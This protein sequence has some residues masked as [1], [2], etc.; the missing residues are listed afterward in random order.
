MCE[1]LRDKVYGLLSF[2]ASC[3][4][5]AIPVDYSLSKYQV[6]GL[7]LEHYCRDHIHGERQLFPKSAQ[8][9]RS[10]LDPASI[11]VIRIY[12]LSNTVLGVTSVDRRPPRHSRSANEAELL[13]LGPIIRRLGLKSQDATQSGLRN[14][15]SFHPDNS[16][17]I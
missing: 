16:R 1:D 5:L 15:Y 3:C 8:G 10:E 4:K 2:A 6:C 13:H 7:V 12:Q 11:P 17:Y 14:V 9:P